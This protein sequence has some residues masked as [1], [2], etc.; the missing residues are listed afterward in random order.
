MAEETPI[1]AV[2]D[3]EEKMRIALRR[4]LSFCGYR[5]ELFE[6]GRDLLDAHSTSP[7]P[8]IVLDL[9]MPEMNGFDVVE[10]LAVH[11]SLPPVVIV[12]GHDKP[13]YSERFRKLGV[14]HHLSKPVDADALV[15]AIEKILAQSTTL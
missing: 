13:G 3:D 8:C 4:L 10:E 7:F 6:T 11:T 14:Q 15:D 12:T 2:L 5:V 9:H 1:I